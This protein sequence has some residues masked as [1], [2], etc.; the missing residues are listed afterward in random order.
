MS[1]KFPDNL[2]QRVSAK[3]KNEIRIEVMSDSM[4]VGKTTAVKVIGE[5][6][7]AKGYSVIESYE[8]W[9][10]NP[11]LKASYSDPAKNFLDSQKWFIKRK[12]QQIVDGAGAAVRIPSLDGGVQV[13]IQDVPPE[14]DYCYAETN[15]RLSRMTNEHFLEYREYYNSLDWTETPAPNLLVYLEVS[16]DELIRRAMDSKR[17]FEEVDPSYFLMMK[18]VNREWVAGAIKSKEYHVLKIDTDHLD[19]AHDIQAKELLLRNVLDALKR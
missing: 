17:E 4:R 6:M 7:R 13:F 12:H 19:F 10:N 2:F 11:Y 1:S 14:M 5:G 3:D 18:K 8:D 15:R 9:Q 16:D